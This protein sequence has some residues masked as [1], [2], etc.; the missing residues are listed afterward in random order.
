MSA[1]R[2]GV[3]P[4]RPRPPYVQELRTK[5][6]STVVDP[7]DDPVPSTGLRA[8]VSGAS[9]RKLG[10]QVLKGRWRGMALYALTLEERATCPETCPLL[11]T[12]YGSG[13][14]FAR[15]NRHGPKLEAAVAHDVAVL[16]GRRACRVGL[17]VRLHVLGDFYSV[18]YVRFWMDQLRAHARLRLFGYTHRQAGTPIGDAVTA[19]VQTF[20]DRA[21]FLRSDPAPVGGAADPLPFARVVPPGGPAVPGSVVCPEQ[22]GRTA[23]CGTCGLCMS[24]RHA[25][26]F[27]EH[28]AHV[29]RR[30]PAPPPAARA[31]RARG[32]RGRALP[33]L[34]G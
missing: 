22:L 11:V 25:I 5:F 19:L 33:V 26:S 30:A 24:G 9:N 13:M 32:P 14:P 4:T 27:L 23:S 21:A 8:L 7:P 3:P 29:T 34:V 12:C 31:A 15:R 10:G 6:P 20:P 2:S 28:G 18:D 17:V 16:L 1:V